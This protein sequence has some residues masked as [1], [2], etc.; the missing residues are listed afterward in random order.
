MNRQ[1]LIALMDSG[2]P[3][4]ADDLRLLERHGWEISADHREARLYSEEWSNV[5]AA[6][7]STKRWIKEST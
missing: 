3:A 6:V 5:H 7:Y 2:A 4:S 1:E